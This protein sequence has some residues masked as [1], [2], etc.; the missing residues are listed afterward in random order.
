MKMLQTITGEDMAFPMAMVQSL[1]KGVF[2]FKE[3]NPEWDNVRNDL[4]MMMRQ[5]T[6][7]KNSTKVKKILAKTHKELESI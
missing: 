6:L 1:R 7:K 3:V 2:P 5:H 4:F